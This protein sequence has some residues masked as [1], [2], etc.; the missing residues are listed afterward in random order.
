M[1]RSVRSRL[2]LWYAAVLTCTLLL[3]S[4]LIYW[5]VKRSVLDRTDAGL[6][7]L[8]DSFLATLDAEL[9]DEPAGEGVVPA[10]QQSMIEH[11]YPGHSFAVLTLGGQLLVS[12]ADLSGRPPEGGRGESSPRISAESLASC[13]AALGPGSERPF[14]SLPG[15]RGG[16][17]CYA[18]SFAAADHTYQLV[19]LASLHP[20]SE[21]LERLR[22]AMGWLIPVTV[23]LA[24]AG[25]YF[26]ARRNLAPVADMTARADQIG[27]STLH[28]RLAVPNPD[29]ELGRLAATF[30][31]LLDRLDL[32]FERQRRFIADAS[33]ELRTPLA[34]LQGE[35]EVA[36]SRA[37][38][39]PEEYRES[40]AI[41]HHEAS[42]LARIVDDML[43]LS[44]ADAGQFPVNLREL[45]LDEL[46][47]ECAQSVRTL[48]AAK[49]IALAV[50]SSGELPVE[51]DESLLS[52]MLLNLL[53]NA[54]KYT[55][56]GG[57]V[58]IATAVTSEGP[59]ITVSDNGPGISQQLQPRIFERFFRADQART[60]A[61][62]GGAGLG[63][64]IAKWIAEAHHGS[65][66]L[67]R[68]GPDGSVFTVRLPAKQ[69]VVSSSH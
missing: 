52:R 41:L 22:V 13:L 51:A 67:T 5:I 24:A 57:K 68:S 63:L 33:H 19:I 53:D 11:Q 44:R 35:S 55:P 26:L 7:E 32:A 12:S 43:T 48:A 23:V 50:E 58:T 14:R 40:L 2:T 60:R 39:S 25:G 54:I 59:R 65:L 8:S 62:S 36:L 21:L 66:E 6:V 56:A 61:N 45:Y 34:I 38:R 30:N 69:E 47:A 64:S 16:T 4:V 3:L 31:R 1:L 10:A 37:G 46:V 17:R 9:R 15:R 29:D 27:E 28:D 42:R 20:E 18:R 49:S